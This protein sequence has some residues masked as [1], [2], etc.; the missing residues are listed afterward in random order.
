MK[1]CAIILGVVL[2]L[3]VLGIVGG[4]IYLNHE[5]APAKVAILDAQIASACE[6]YLAVYGKLPEPLENQKFFAVLAG[7]NTNDTVFFT[8]DASDLNSDGELVD[9]WGTPFKI[10]ADA[11]GNLTI[12][13][14]G[15]D[16]K[17]QTKDD[18]SQ[19]IM[20]DH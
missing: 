6:N 7:Q 1:T 20:G 9:P 15:P 3:G 18:I 12:I 17:F 4:V 2:L 16:R 10:T 13:S 11:K 14:A 19:F 8:P 5:S